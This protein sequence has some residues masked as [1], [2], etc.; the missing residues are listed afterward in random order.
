VCALLHWTLHTHA[1]PPAPPE[2]LPLPP[3]RVPGGC[4]RGTASSRR[5]CPVGLQVLQPASLPGGLS[6]LHDLLQ[7]RFPQA[8]MLMRGA[9]SEAA[10]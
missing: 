6:R 4:G 9:G 7:R 10:A 1:A 3:V 2:P 8:P 5:R